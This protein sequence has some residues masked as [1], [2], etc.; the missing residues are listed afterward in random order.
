MFSVLLYAFIVGFAEW[1]IEVWKMSVSQS[2]LSLLFQKPLEPFHTPKKDVNG[3]G[4]VEFIVSDAYKTE[5]YDDMAYHPPQDPYSDLPIPQNGVH[6]TFTTTTTFFNQPITNYGP[7]SAGTRTRIIKLDSTDLPD[8]SF[9]KKLQETDGFSL[10]N[11][12]HLEIAGRLT[13]I[14]IDADLSKLLK[15]AS[16]ARKELNPFLFQYAFSVALQH[17]PDTS[18]VVVPNIATQFPIHFIA[19]SA[20]SFARTEL[21]EYANRRDIDIKVNFS[22]TDKDPEQR[23]AYFREGSCLMN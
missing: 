13:K 4:I 16:Y 1:I 5:R 7:T 23:M 9:A 12:T 17:R 10:F 15:I 3:N 14:F 2:D 22:A 6:S 18:D 21:V 8:L 20:L 11:E 19:T